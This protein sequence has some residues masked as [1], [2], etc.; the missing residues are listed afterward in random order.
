M[1]PSSLSIPWACKFTC[2]SAVGEFHSDALYLMLPQLT[3]LLLLSKS[4][5]HI[6]LP[7]PLSLSPI[8][9]ARHRDAAASVVV[10]KYHIPR[11][12]CLFLFLRQRLRCRRRLR[13]P[14]SER[15]LTFG[16]LTS[17]FFWWQ[18]AL[19][20]VERASIPNLVG[21]DTVENSWG[22]N[23][24]PRLFDEEYTILWLDFDLC[25]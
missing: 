10:P 9:Q 13:G 7:T 24:I 21:N 6:P 16:L 2:A 4:Q 19:V 12:N 25:G 8:T 17:Y 1:P 20:T 18:F 5:A 23:W 3:H 22:A 11:T 15:L 14:F